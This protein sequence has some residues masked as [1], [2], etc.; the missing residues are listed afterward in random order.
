VLA[1]VHFLANKRQLASLVNGEES[2]A[3]VQA[4]RHIDESAVRRDHTSG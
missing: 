4:V 3:V 2:D 1:R